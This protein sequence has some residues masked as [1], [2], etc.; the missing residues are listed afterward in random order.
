M[1]RTRPARRWKQATVLSSF[2]FLVLTAGTLALLARPVPPLLVDLA[3]AAALLV[4][5]LPGDATVK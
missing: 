4:A 1:V 3:V 5:L 2:A